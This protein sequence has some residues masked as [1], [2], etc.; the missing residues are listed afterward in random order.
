MKVWRALEE[1]YEAGK[2]RAIGVSNFSETDLQKLTKKAKIKPMINQ[3][4]THI[5]NTP[6]QLIEFCQ[7]NNIMV[8]A[9]SPI[10]HGKILDHPF[11]KE[12]AEKYEVTIPQLC[13]RYCLDLGLVTI[14]KSQTPAHMKSN[15]ELDFEISPEDLEALKA[16][17][18]IE[19]YGEFDKYSVFSNAFDL[20]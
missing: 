15:I 4:L 5:S 19:S 9:Y 6:T 3:V 11:I 12:M 16:V 13:I 8:E 2:A 10:G 20:N 7:N 17:D 18:R 1:M 14:P